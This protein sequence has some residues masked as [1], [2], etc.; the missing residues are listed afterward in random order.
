MIPPHGPTIRKSRNS[1]IRNTIN[2]IAQLN[3][4]SSWLFSDEIPFSTA[5]GLMK[6]AAITPTVN[7]APNANTIGSI[8]SRNSSIM[9]DPGSLIRHPRDGDDYLAHLASVDQVPCH[10][11]T[12]AVDRECTQ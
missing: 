12:W 11:M 9:L 6:N 7:R 8:S 10:L 5:D 1:T 3:A 4:P 2:I